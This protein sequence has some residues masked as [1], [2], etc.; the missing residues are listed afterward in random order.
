M[1]QH[2]GIGSKDIE[3]KK[4]RQKEIEIEGITRRQEERDSGWSI[5]TPNRRGENI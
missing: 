5:S 1:D 2:T 3:G 4:L